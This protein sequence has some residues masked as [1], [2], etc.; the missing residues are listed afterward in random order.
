M[1]IFL[2]I[3][4]SGFMKKSYGSILFLITSFLLT[5]GAAFAGDYRIGFGV[6]QF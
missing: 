6:S 1:V 5:S 4:F 2:T 3:L